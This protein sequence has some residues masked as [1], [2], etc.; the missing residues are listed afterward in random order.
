MEYSTL[1]GS[2]QIDGMDQVSYRAGDRAAMKKDRK[3]DEWIA[4]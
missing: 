3:H 1:T 2:R 4:P